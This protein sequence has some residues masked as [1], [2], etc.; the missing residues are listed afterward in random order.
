MTYRKALAKALSMLAEGDTLI[1]TRLD[2][3]ARSTGDLLNI[4]DRITRAG[5]GFKSLGMP[6]IPGQIRPRRMAGLC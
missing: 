1:V 4:P 3:L 5:A 2:R 6:R